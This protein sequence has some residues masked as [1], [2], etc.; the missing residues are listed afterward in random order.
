MNC[1]MKLLV[2]LL[3][4]VETMVGVVGSGAEVPSP[5]ELKNITAAA[6]DRPGVRPKRPRKV[7]VFSRSFGYKH[8]AIPYGKKAVEIMGQ[9]TGAFEAVLSDDPAMFEPH[10]LMQFDAVVFNNTNR[11][12]FRP[13]NFDELPPRQRAEA[14]KRD[15][16]LK[17][18]LADF[19][20]G[21]KGLAVIHA[22]VASFREWPEYEKIIGARFDNHPWLSGSTVTLKVDDPCH[23]VAGAF[24]GKSLE[25]TDEI[26]QVKT[27]YSRRN[28]RVLLSIDTAKTCIKLN[29]VKDIHRQDNDFAISWVKSYGKGR[30]FYCA[31]G[32]QH[33]LFWNPVILQHFLDGI[34]F[35]LGDLEGDTT[36]SAKGQTDVPARGAN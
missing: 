22:G 3:M 14:M 6:P 33:E 35:V 24:K 31:L 13:E 36:P 11:E 25:V 4:F 5:Q 21:G 17:N 19:I 1:R 34:Q 18:S 16:A 2:V 28:L 23:P 10:N 27:P 29:R 15:E 26:Y 30:V 20:A 12:I 8:T 32:H 7:L 9:K